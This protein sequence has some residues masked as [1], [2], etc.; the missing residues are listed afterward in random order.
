MPTAWSS[1]PALVWGLLVTSSWGAWLALATGMAVLH[2]LSAPWSA[3][4]GAGLALA[5]LSLPCPWSPLWRVLNALPRGASV[6]SLRQRRRLWRIMASQWRVA[7]PWGTG[8]DSMS[9]WARRWQVA[10]R[11]PLP[12]GEAHSEP[13]QL[14]W[15]YGVAGALTVVLVAW[16]VG[17]G[18]QWGDPWSAAAVV[19]GVLCLG[20]FPL[21]VAPLGIVVLVVW[22]RVAP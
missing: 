18:L 7:W 10:Y 6:D 5:G 19:A 1:Q 16:R 22:A 9:R 2:P 20:T 15:E 4:V 12:L 13:L 3:L 14:A 21:R 17:R 8:P 11:T